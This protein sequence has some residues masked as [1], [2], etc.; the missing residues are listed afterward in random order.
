MTVHETYSF[1]I[2]KDIM[3]QCAKREGINC[4]QT[5]MV[6]G[7]GR[8]ITDEDLIATAETCGIA[9]K[10]VKDMIEQVMTAAS[11]ESIITQHGKRNFSRTI[12]RSR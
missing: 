5:A 6:N 8:D 7:K 9:R 2:P 1:L 4:E 3:Q 12:E 10:I 11:K